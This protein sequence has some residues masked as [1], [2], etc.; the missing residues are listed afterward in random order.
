MELG[1][2]QHIP[3]VDGTSYPTRTGNA[4][5][6]LIDGVPAFWRICEAVE[7]AQYS[8][9]LTVAFIHPEFAMPDG[10]GS[11]FDVLDDAVQR[12]LDVRVIFW[13]TNGEP[14][15]NDKTIFSGLPEHWQ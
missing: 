6:P 13:R 15:L 1:K 3:F 2:F 7:E 5:R 14:D 8:V 9:F 10:R 12:G 11:L 4:V